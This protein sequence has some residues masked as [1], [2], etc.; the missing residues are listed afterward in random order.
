ML[1]QHAISVA[2][3][4]HLQVC[5]SKSENAPTQRLSLLPVQA[6]VRKSATTKPA[7]VV[8]LRADEP[9]YI[10]QVRWRSCFAL[11]PAPRPACVTL[12]SRA[13]AP[14]PLAACGP[15]VHHLHARVLRPHGP[16]DGSHHCAGTCTSL[17]SVSRRLHPSDPPSPPP[18]HPS[19]NRSSWRSAPLCRTRPP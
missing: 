8:R 18:P 9:I 10:L 7:S 14:G 1:R 16:R 3:L 13:L 19:S 5:G 11:C 17:G 6:L 4:P 15:H 2:F 12:C